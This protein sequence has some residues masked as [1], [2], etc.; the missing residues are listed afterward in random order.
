[1]TYTLIGTGNTAWFLSTKLAAAGHI[2]AGIFA[3][4]LK[5]AELLANAI[6]SKA[7]S[8]N[9]TAIPE[10][11]C[12]IIAVSDYA[13]ANVAAQLKFENTVVIHSAG[14]IDI[15]IL[16][17]TSNK[18]GVL[19]PIYSIVKNN[20]PEERNIPSVWEASDPDTASVIHTIAQ[21]YTDVIFQADSTKRKWLHL[22]AVMSNN[23]TNHLFAISEKLCEE[24]QLPFSLLLPIIQQSIQRLNTNSAFSQQTGPAKRNDNVIIAKHLEMLDNH[25]EWQ[26]LYD[27]ISRS[28]M[29]M[30]KQP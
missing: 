12:C 29:A 10:T 18:Y 17:T 5:N 8:L 16:T 20:L 21:S 4:N 22:T 13:I 27:D 28:I 15:N 25:P 24:Q 2:C 9:V 7:Y 19:W 11:D 6:N 3:R 26:K 23:F 14:A 30:Y 1:M